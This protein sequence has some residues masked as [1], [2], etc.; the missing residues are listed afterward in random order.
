[1]Y[2]RFTQNLG[3][4]ARALYQQIAER[5]HKLEEDIRLVNADIHNS[6]WSEETK[7]HFQA[8]IGSENWNYER[9]KECLVQMAGEAK[10]QLKLLNQEGKK[11]DNRIEKLSTGQKQRTSIARCLINRGIALTYHFFSLDTL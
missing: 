11:A 5:K 9:M 6:A 8:L 4:R 1:M 10:E 2:E 3:L 7:E